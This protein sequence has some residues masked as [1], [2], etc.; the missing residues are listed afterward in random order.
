MK[1]VV[2]VGA[3]P[4]GLV[5]LKEMLESGL[6]AILFERSNKLGG[7]FSSDAVYPDLH[8]TISN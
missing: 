7:L 6:E 2:I 5:A 4:C 3:G 8:L 1:S